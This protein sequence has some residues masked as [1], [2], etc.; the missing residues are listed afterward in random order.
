MRAE[1]DAI[2]VGAGTLRQ[3]DPSLTVRNVR[4][5]NPFRVVV[6]GSSPLPKNSR[7]F[8]NNQDARTVVV[9]SSKRIARLAKDK[10]YR[11]VTFWTV[12]E[13]RG[14][15]DIADLVKQAGAFG[16][17]SMLVEGGSALATSFLKAKLVDRLVLIVAPKLLGDGLS[18]IGDLGIRRLANHVPLADI[19]IGGSGPDLI[20]QAYPNW[21]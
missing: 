9:A 21:Q 3:D 10:A 4:G 13:K 8:K 15:A 11:G 5:R 19:M 14:Q 16:L 18:A 6:A 17:T 2:L 20:V 7:L 1:S 12:K